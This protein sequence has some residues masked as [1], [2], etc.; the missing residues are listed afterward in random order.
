MA[1]AFERDVVLPDGSTHQ[2]RT[3]AHWRR[4]ALLVSNIRARIEA[5]SDAR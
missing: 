1:S 2:G 5:D 3:P 4:I